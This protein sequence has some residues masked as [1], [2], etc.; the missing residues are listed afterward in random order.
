MQK[1]LHFNATYAIGIKTMF[2]D[3]KLVAWSNQY[4]DECKKPYE[5]IRTAVGW[6]D[7]WCKKSVQRDVIIPFHF[8]PNGEID[9]PYVVRPNS[10]L[11]QAIVA[12]AKAS[13]DPYRLGIALHSLQDSYSH[14][15]WTGWDEK[16]NECYW[17]SAIPYPMPNVGHTNMGL[18]PDIVRAKWYDPRTQTV[19]T[20]WIRVFDAL[21]YTGKILCLSTRSYRPFFDVEDYDNGKQ[22]FAD[23]CGDNTQFSDIKPTKKMKHYFAEAAKQQLKIVKE[24]ISQFK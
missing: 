4:T 3:I 5:G 12:D 11:C 10:T 8:L 21:D 23:W 22:W 16:F 13:G 14:Q 6:V 18:A 1:D 15:G 9:N 17:F 7:D 19:I 20:N 2:P 24:Y